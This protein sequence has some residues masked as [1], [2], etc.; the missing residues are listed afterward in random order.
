MPAPSTKPAGQ[1][2]KVTAFVL[3]R[4]SPRMVLAFRHPSAGLQFPAGTVEPAEDFIEA[5]R[6][7]VREETMVSEIGEGAVLAVESTSPGSGQAVL[8]C[9]VLA[10]ES[11]GGR[12]GHNLRRGHPV[13]VVETRDDHAR[14]C[15]DE[16]NLNVVPPRI[17]SSISGWVLRET[18]A[19]QVPRAFVAFFFDGD[20]EDAPWTCAADGHNFE[21]SW[22]PLTTTERFAGAQMQWLDRYRDRLAVL[23][24]PLSGPGRERTR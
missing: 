24:P 6:R 5:A 20:V 21:V 11:P 18:L 1:I 3:T 22:F 2:A 4:G 14:V 10:A 23:S 15:Q 16:W 12:E 19:F 9:D 7:E 17:E 8:T 13:R